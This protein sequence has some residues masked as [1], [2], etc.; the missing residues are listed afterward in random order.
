MSAERP[1]LH[2]NPRG[3]AIRGR[4]HRAD[5]AVLCD[6]ALSL[7][8]AAD[9]EVVVCDVGAIVDPDASAIDAL[10]R[11]QLSARRVGRRICLS[12][13]SR[14]LEGL[15]ALMG[16]G[17]VVPLDAGSAL[18]PRGEPEQREIACGV[19]EEAD[20]GDLPA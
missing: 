18:Q 15:L 13:A 2:P 3:L 11:L 4:I 14:E 5:V 17:E 1:A 16:L 9:T 8:E 12:H 20:P 10:A 6:R 7:I 19:E